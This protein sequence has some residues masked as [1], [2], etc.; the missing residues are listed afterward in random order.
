MQELGRCQ[1]QPGDSCHACCSSELSSSRSQAGF[2]V[3]SGPALHPESGSLCSCWTP[4]YSANLAFH[5]GA[6]DGEAVE[7]RLGQLVPGLW[8]ACF[9]RRAP[10]P[11]ICVRR[12]ARLSRSEGSSIWD[13]SMSQPP[14]QACEPLVR[15]AS[16]LPVQGRPQLGEVWRLQHL[17][18]PRACHRV[19][20]RCGA[21][22]LR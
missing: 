5:M 2:P 15:E 16:S 8:E 12:Q 14:A 19:C 7:L 11:N 6:C 18:R 22:P 13:D 21:R 10:T 4:A 9:P 17:G 3:C 1:Q 20:W